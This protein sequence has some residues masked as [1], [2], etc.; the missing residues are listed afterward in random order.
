MLTNMGRY[1]QG[2]PYPFGG[3]GKIPFGAHPPT[4]TLKQVNFI[5]FIAFGGPKA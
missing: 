1:I 2:C 5:L 4:K 3:Q